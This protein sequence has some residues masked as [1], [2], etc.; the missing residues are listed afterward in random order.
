MNEGG[1]MRSI[2]L[3][4]AFTGLGLLLGCGPSDSSN[5]SSG[6]SSESD[7]SGNISSSGDA[8][9]TN[10]P[11]NTGVNVRDRADAALTPLDQGGSEADRGLTASIRQIVTQ[12]QFS[13]DAKNIKIITENGKVTLRGPVKD[14]QERQAIESAVKKVSGVSAVDNQLEP[15]Q[16]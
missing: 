2:H 11:D 5:T 10:A 6:A 15:K 14:A 1:M 8:T 3:M 13:T 9:T 16:Q 7:T 4:A 12:D